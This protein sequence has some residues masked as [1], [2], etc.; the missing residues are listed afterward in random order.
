VSLSFLPFLY[1][2]ASLHFMSVRYIWYMGLGPV[3]CNALYVYMV[4]SCANWKYKRIIISHKC[5]L[6]LSS[7][8]LEPNP[9]YGVFSVNPL[10][11]G[12]DHATCEILPFGGFI[13]PFYLLSIQGFCL[14]E[15]I[16]QRK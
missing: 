15:S 11:V 1:A 10:L 16:Q 9:L 3:L 14:K 4:L 13:I 6:F 8:Y 7:W 2:R 12:G 5:I